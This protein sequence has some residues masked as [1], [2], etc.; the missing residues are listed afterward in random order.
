M[1]LLPYH[2]KHLDFVIAKALDFVN[3]FKAVAKYFHVPSDT[4]P[5]SW[6]APCPGIVKVNFNQANLGNWSAGWG[7]V[8]HDSSGAIPF[9]EVQ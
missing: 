3:E 6:K 5:S 1:I 9:F 8:S 7:M 2:G 4:S